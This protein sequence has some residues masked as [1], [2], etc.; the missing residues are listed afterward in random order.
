[1]T[2]RVILRVTEKASDLPFTL[3]LHSEVRG[4][5]MRCIYHDLSRDEPMLV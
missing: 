1:M 4:R 3:L 5:R 2:L